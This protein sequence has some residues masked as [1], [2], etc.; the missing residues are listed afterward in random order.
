[1]RLASLLLGLA[2]A[3]ARPLAA[4][5]P[6]GWAFGAGGY[7]IRFADSESRTFSTLGGPAGQVSLLKPNG[8]GFD[9]RA[10]YILPSGFYDMTGVSAI[11]GGTYGWPVAGRHLVQAKAGIAGFLGGDNDGSILN[12]AGPYAGG[13]MTF[14]VGGRFGLQVEALARTYTSSGEWLFAP[15][16]AVTLMLLPK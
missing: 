4:Q 8:V 10:G 2:L 6:D 16:G 13:A 3:A 15:S 9:F 14:R 7:V 11:L 1:M 12:G 5:V